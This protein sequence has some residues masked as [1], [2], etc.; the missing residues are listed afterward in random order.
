MLAAP[1]TVRREVSFQLVEKFLAACSCLLFPVCEIGTVILAPSSAAPLLNEGQVLS[2]SGG[3]VWS[4]SCVPGAGLR[5]SQAQGG[6]VSCQG[7][8]AT[9]R[10][11]QGGNE[12]WQDPKPESEHH[13]AWP[14]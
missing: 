11:S 2:R 5:A 7:R 1:G 9:E 12:V 8:M 10:W 4:A 6:P 13:P 14:L 3:C